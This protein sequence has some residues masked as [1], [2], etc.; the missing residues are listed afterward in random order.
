MCSECAST[1]HDELAIAEDEMVYQQSLG[2]GEAKV[3]QPSKIFIGSGEDVQLE[4]V[5]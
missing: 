3:V 5:C 2:C 4:D 1:L